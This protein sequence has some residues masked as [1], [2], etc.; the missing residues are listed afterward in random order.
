MGLHTA[1]FKGRKVR[2]ITRH[3]RVIV[4]RFLDRKGNGW[5]VLEHQRIHQKDIRAFS[6]FKKMESV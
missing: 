3:G 4:D 5:V 2:I 1:T 6:P